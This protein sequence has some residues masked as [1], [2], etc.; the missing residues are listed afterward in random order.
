MEIERKFLIENENLPASLEEYP[1]HKIEQG[2][3]CTDPVVRIRQE[4]ERPAGKAAR[5]ETKALRF[6]RRCFLGDNFLA[7]VPVYRYRR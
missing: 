3:L 2:Y 6:V 7:A 1:C 5:D 4:D